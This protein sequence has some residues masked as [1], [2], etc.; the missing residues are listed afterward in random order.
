MFGSG[1]M[2]KSNA[3]VLMCTYNGARFL[4]QQLDS[5]VSQHH[6]DWALWVS[7]D[8]S[9]DN[10]CEIIKAFSENASQPVTWL[11]GP[12]QGFF[13]NFLSLL[14]NQEI[15]ADYYFFSD[16][17]DIWHPDKMSRAI[18]WLQKQPAG[19]PALYC[20]RT[21]LVDE[22]GRSLGYSPLFSRKPSFA[23]AIVQSVAGGNTMAMNGA[24]RRVLV[25]MSQQATCRSHDWWAYIV[26]TAV[27]AAFYY[28]PQATIDY[29]QHGN[30][31]VGSNKGILALMLRLKMLVKGQFSSWNAQHVEQLERYEH[32]LT[33]S[34]RRQ[35]FL[36]KSLK[37]ASF[38]CRLGTYVRGPFYRQTLLGNLGLLLAVVLKR[39]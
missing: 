1:A 38:A 25:T 12:C 27:G 24:M 35:L 9:F 30:N 23:N 33:P 32:L 4:P 7:D 11:N 39:L 36:F 26:A 31:Q 13:Q 8:G 2:V 16:Q 5:L 28:D 3:A 37:S 20:S 10:T 15:E 6:T 22:Q 21:H 19:K 18:A 17:D 29:R 14:G 34:S